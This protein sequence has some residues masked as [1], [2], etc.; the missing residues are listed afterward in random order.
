MAAI[1]VLPFENLS[2]DKQNTCRENRDQSHLKIVS[3]DW[4]FN[5]QLAFLTDGPELSEPFWQFNQTLLPLPPDPNCIYLGTRR[6]IASSST[7]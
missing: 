2:D 3:L 6:S 7:T 1:A 5:E 4:A